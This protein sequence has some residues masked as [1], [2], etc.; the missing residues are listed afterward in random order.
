MFAPTLRENRAEGWTSR[1][2]T[3]DFLRLRHYALYH[4]I[5]RKNGGRW[6]PRRSRILNQL[7]ILRRHGRAEYDERHKRM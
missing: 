2:E 5:A 6:G 4:P 7:F 1:C 3:H